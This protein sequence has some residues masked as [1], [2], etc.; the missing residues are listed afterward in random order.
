MKKNIVLLCLFSIGLFAKAQEK[1]YTIDGYIKGLKS[2]YV[3]LS[4]E[5]KKDSIPVKDGRFHYKGQVTE[6]TPVYIS[7]E[8]SFVRILFIEGGRTE[9][10]GNA[11]AL[12]DVQIDGGKTQKEWNILENSI[13]ELLAERRVLS[14]EFH[15]ANKVPDL[16]A[17]DIVEAKQDQL[18]AKINQFGKG[19]ILKNPKSYVSLQQIQNIQYANSDYEESVALYEKIDPNLK[20]SRLAKQIE[21]VLALLKRGSIGQKMA[22]FTQNDPF[23]KPI[24]LSSF[25]GKYVLVDFWAAWCGPCRAENPNVLKAYKAFE[26]KGFTVLGV[27][28]DSDAEKW[29]KAIEDDQLPWTQ[30]S[31]LKGWRNAVSTYF[32]IK[33]IP[34][35]YLVDPNGII[36]AKNLQGIDLENKLKELIR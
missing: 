5:R 35:N 4:I 33:G 15:R 3:Y 18:E 36:V 13:K 14:R 27:S 34:S 25:K 24:S 23:G 21:D 16:A 26:N 6:P 10:K 2:A 22:E 31:D 8:K 12:E 17:R 32:G 30:V 19:F 11:R 29:K 1:E 20:K 9:I 28:L 7:F